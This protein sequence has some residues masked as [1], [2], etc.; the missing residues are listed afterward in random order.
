MPTW[1]DKLRVERKQ[2]TRRRMMSPLKEIKE[3]LGTSLWGCFI[4]DKSVSIKAKMSV[5][6]SETEEP[7]KQDSES[8]SI[9]SGQFGLNS[10]GKT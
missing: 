10:P 4:L 3:A 6:C 2:G 1:E 9:T 8:G 7:A 5:A